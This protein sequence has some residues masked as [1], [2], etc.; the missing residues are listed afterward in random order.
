LPLSGSSV[1]TKD[2]PAPGVAVAG[3]PTGQSRHRG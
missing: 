3:A 2:L 1:R